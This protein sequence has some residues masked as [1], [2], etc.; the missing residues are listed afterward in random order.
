ME[1]NAYPGPDMIIFCVDGIFTLTMSGTNEDN[2]RSGDLDITDSLTIRGN[3]VQKT[4]IDG[5]G[6]ML[7]D[8]VFHIDPAG[9]GPTVSIAFVAIQNGHATPAGEG[10]GVLNGVCRAT[11]AGCDP[12]ARESRLTMDHVIIRSNSV[13][14]IAY[15]R[16]GGISN[17]GYLHLTNTTIDGNSATVSGGLN[18]G[19]GATAEI[20]QVV[21]SNNTASLDTGASVWAAGGGLS[22][23]ASATMTITNSRII[24]NHAPQGSG[25]GIVNHGTLDLENTQISGNESGY[26]GGGIFTAGSI[27]AFNV[28]INQNTAAG[29]G[30]IYNAV[31]SNLILNN[32]ILNRV[33]INDNRALSITSGGGGIYNAGTM[34]LINVTLSNNTADGAGGGIHNGT[35]IISTLTNVTLYGNQATQGGGIDNFGVAAAIILTNTIVADSPKG[36]NCRGQITSNGHNLDSA[37]SCGFAKPGDIINRDPHLY[38]LEDNGGFN[39]THRL[40]A[41]SEFIKFDGISYRLIVIS[42]AVDAGDSTSCPPTDQRGVIRPIGNGCDIGAFEFP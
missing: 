20:D 41:G 24:N 32:L 14:G 27:D 23:S 33:T 10:G 28:T 1:A 2:A 37:N 22:N 25:G 17:N 29:G 19:L 4:I 34:E 3:G 35:S 31:D 18:N 16:G 42:P 13:S 11:E 12:N 38:P 8:R 7:K 30:G 26:R 5:G 9:D 39:Q 36:N 21:I 15:A 6:I 40:G